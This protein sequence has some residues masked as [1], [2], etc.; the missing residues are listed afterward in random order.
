MINKAPDIRSFA[1]FI[2]PHRKHSNN[3]IFKNRFKIVK[4]AI[5]VIDCFIGL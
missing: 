5:K 1:F 2:L 3:Q 4:P